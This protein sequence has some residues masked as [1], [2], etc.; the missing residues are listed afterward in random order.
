MKTHAAFN[1]D[2]GRLEI[3]SDR[4][5]VWQA[6]ENQAY[7]GRI[8]FRLKRADLGSLAHCMPHE[9]LSLHRCIAA[10]ESVLTSLFQPDRFNYGQMGNSYHQLHVHAVP[11]Y[12]SLRSWREIQFTDLRWGNNWS[13]TPKSPIDPEQTYQFASFLRHYIDAY[14]RSGTAL[15]QVGA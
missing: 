11:R 2:Y 7:L 4:D 6:H 1:I 10:Y 8:I 14:K 5:W 13:P 9:W 3:F 12:A 15:P